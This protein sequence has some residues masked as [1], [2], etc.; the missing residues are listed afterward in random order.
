MNANARAFVPQNTATRTNTSS[1]PSISRA[2][3]SPGRNFVSNQNSLQPDLRRNSFKNQNHHV[4]G[5][6]NGIYKYKLLFL[7][8][9]FTDCYPV[10]YRT[11]QIISKFNYLA[12]SNLSNNKRSNNFHRKQ[13]RHHQRNQIDDVKNSD[14]SGSN[15]AGEN[16]T[17]QAEEIS[18]S[19]VTVAT[20]LNDLS[21]N[22]TGSMVRHIRC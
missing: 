16:D 4:Q 20:N 15:S 13:N 3:R 1:S 21:L 19:V 22:D 11:N 14:R 17:N 10:I 5:D 7:S 12:R 9:T 18:S 2:Q 8:I 6:Q